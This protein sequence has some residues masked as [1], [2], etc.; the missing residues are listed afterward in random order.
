[1]TQSTLVTSKRH[2]GY[3]TIAYGIAALLVVFGHSHPIHMGNPISAVI[4]FIYEFHM[5]LFFTISGILIGYTQKSA[6]GGRK[7]TNASDVF[8]WWLKKVKKLT[9]PYL[10]LTAL[11]IIPKF[12]LGDMMTDDM[13]LSTANVLMIFL[14]PRKGIWGHFWFVPTYLVLS[15][16]TSL[17]FHFLNGISKKVRVG[18]YLLI[19]AVTIFLNYN[20]IRIDYF[21]IKDITKNFI[22]CIAGLLISSIYINWNLNR[23][24]IGIVL[25]VI[26]IAVSVIMFLV[27]GDSWIIGFL[28]S[29]VMS[30]TVLIVAKLID[31]KKDGMKKALI[32]T[33][34]LEFT[35]NNAFTI[36]LYS[37]PIQ[38]VLELLL[39]VVIG[40]NW[41]IVYLAL[42][43]GGL[44]GPLLIVQ[45]YRRFFSKYKWIGTILGIV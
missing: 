18:V 43:A 7:F 41:I 35:G 10:V 5:P 39:T 31:T 16:I 23:K 44:F 45:I 29:L 36:F 15:L 2:L 4:D 24:N 32:V 14:A 8:K 9:I 40:C 21:A 1:M 30:F 12:I 22:Y 13:T 28:I 25:T 3:I 37:W 26:G 34:C 38:A 17:I 19:V 6:M 33:K 42:F 20:P 11:G 27:K